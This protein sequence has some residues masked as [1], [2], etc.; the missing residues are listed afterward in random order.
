VIFEA[1]SDG[2][3]SKCNFLTARLD[4]R[5]VQPQ[6]DTF[7]T[8]LITTVANKWAT[9]NSFKKTVVFITA[10]LL[11]NTIFLLPIETNNFYACIVLGEGHLTT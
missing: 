7:M 6:Q 8:L 3:I 5:A 10:V 11:V 1:N 4:I 2:N 9:A